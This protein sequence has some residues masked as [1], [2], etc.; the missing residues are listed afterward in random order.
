[1]VANFSLFFLFNAW[2]SKKIKDLHIE[3]AVVFLNLLLVVFILVF[4][5]LVIRVL[6]VNI[7]RSF[8]NHWLAALSGF[9]ISFW[10]PQHMFCRNFYLSRNI[11][12]LSK[13]WVNQVCCV[14]TLKR[15]TYG[16]S[17]IVNVDIGM[18]FCRLWFKDL[19]SSIVSISS[20][21]TLIALF[22]HHELCF[23]FLCM[24]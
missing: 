12:S 8:F 4:P 7:W 1:M 2:Y 10:N 11:V 23:V 15:I 22:E 24:W 5:P 16:S 20:W 13:I 9:N 21:K 18:K 17:I 6:V 19:S 3:W 14:N